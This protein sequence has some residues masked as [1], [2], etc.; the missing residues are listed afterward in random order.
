MHGSFIVTFSY[1]VPNTR[2][3]S[4]MSSGK[5]GRSVALSSRSDDTVIRNS[6][7]ALMFEKPLERNSQPMARV[8]GGHA[9]YLLPLSK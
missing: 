4:V 6:H 5:N 9:R 3:Y 1:G 2:A 8:G 7:P